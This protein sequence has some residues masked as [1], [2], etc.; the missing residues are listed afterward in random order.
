MPDPAPAI[1]GLDIAKNVF[2]AHGAD[3]AG[4]RVLGRRLRRGEVAAF[5]AR[6]PPSLVGSEACPGAHHW[7]RALQALGHGGKRRFPPA[8]P[9]PVREAL[10]RRTSPTPPTPRRSA[11]PWS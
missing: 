11:R 4:R 2:Q 5:F 8:A 7:A 3:A 9:A 6:L 10:R 1:V